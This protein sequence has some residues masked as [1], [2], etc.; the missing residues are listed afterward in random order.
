M[1]II[2]TGKMSM[3]SSINAAF[4]KAKDA[5]AKDGASPDTII[6]QLSEDI[7]GAV[8]AYVT[9]ITVMINPGIAVSAAGVMGPVVGA[10]T[11]PGSS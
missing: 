10:T 6:K 11:S 9:S 2:A 8:D 5:G 3:Q 1:P 7:A 4:V